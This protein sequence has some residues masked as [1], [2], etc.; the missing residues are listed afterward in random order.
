MVVGMQER[1]HIHATVDGG[2][3]L[4]G[5]HTGSHQLVGHGVRDTDQMM[6][7]TGRKSLTT[8]KEL[9]SRARAES[10]GMVRRGQYGSLPAH[11]MTR[12]QVAPA[13]RLWHCACGRHRAETA[14]MHVS[15]RGR[16]SA[17]RAGWIGRRRD[18]ISGPVPPLPHPAPADRL[19]AQGR[20]GDQ[21]HVV[22][23]LVAR[24]LAAQQS[25][26]LSAAD[27]HSRDNV[28]NLQRSVSRLSVGRC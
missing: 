26:L 3:F 11:P 18:G 6:A 22:T 25:V 24:V 23:E 4:A 7:A 27:N 20:A 5:S 2:E 19:R 1:L 21:Q 16:R 8:S 10:R 28:C 14:A 13:S 9:A 12:R 17:S 15:V